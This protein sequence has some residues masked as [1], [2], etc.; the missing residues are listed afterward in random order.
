MYARFSPP[1]ATRVGAG[2][3]PV[4]TFYPASKRPGWI[5]GAPRGFSRSFPIL[6]D[7]PVDNVENRVL[8]APIP[9]LYLAL[10]CMYTDG[11]IIQVPPS[12]GALFGHPDNIP[13]C[14]W[15]KSTRHAGICTSIDLP[16]AFVDYIWALK[17]TNSTGAP[18]TTTAALKP[19]T[20][21]EKTIQVRKR[22]QREEPRFLFTSPK[23]SG[24]GLNP[25]SLALAENFPTLAQPA[26]VDGTRREIII[27][28][29]TGG[30][31]TQD[32]QSSHKRNT[33]GS[34]TGWGKDRS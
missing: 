14:L 31:K 25:N 18:P 12:P 3:G 22:S 1:K 7:R 21:Q 29:S 30:C 28:T 4:R 6:D 26:H 16:S 11:T 9:I 17:G 2:L 20:E 23:R 8:R 32:I 15:A 10:V 34:S 19:P 33:V 13:R 24:L 27:L 5:G